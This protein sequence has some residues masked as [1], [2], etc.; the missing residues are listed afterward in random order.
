MVTA[1]VESGCLTFTTDLAEAAGAEVHFLCVGTPQ[2]S[3]GHAADLTAL[4]TAVGALVP[5]LRESALVVGK[6]TVPV[7]TAELIGERLRREA[8][9]GPEARI[10]W[11]PEF[12][13]EGHAVQDSLRPERLVLGVQD[14]IADQLLREVYA[15]LINAGVPVVRTDLAT[16]ELAKV[17]ANVMLATR[18]SLVNLLAEVCEAAQADVG[19][20]TRILGLDT[21]IGD[22]FLAP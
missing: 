2:Q 11:N 18:V 3:G 7:G 14:D 16:A 20:L 1:G 6:S 15:P 13:R 19:D 21:R 9:A 17:S 22:R 10:A 12:L 4:H 5:L 8:P